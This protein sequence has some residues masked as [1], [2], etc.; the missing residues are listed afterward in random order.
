MRVCGADIPIPYNPILEK[1]AV[2]T[3]EKIESA[4]RKA[5]AL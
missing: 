2:P 4:V 5:M 1:N 3:P